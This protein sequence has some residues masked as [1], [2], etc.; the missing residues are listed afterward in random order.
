MPPMHMLR[1]VLMMLANRKTFAGGLFM[2]RRSLGKAAGG[3]AS[4]VGAAATPDA[5]AWRKAFEVV[6]VDSTGWLNLAASLSKAAVKQARQAALYSIQML[7]LGTPEAFD[8]I[9]GTRQR[10]VRGVG[11][12]EGWD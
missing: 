11:R 6:F 4:G 10:L 2:L 5:R 7:N 12:G 3:S 1:L 8:A 9:F